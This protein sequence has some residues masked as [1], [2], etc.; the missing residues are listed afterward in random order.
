VLGKHS[1]RHAFAEQLAA[2][3]V[4][5]EG[6]ALERAFDR[7][8][9]LADRKKHLGEADLVAIASS[10]RA[11][12]KPT[13]VL[14]GLQ[15]GCGTMGL[16]TAT[17]RLRGPDEDVRIHAAVGTGPVD[18]AFKA[19]DG[20]VGAR[21]TLVEY[22]VHSVTEGIDALGE[23]SVRVRPFDPRR[24]ASPQTDEPR[25]RVVH[26]HGADTDIVVASAKAYLAALNR[27]LDDT[28]A[29]AGPLPANP[30][31]PMRE[32]PL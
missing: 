7:F 3:G 19:I 30:P 9:A 12:S 5:L 8:K 26:G 14:D 24:V 13:F 28:A 10:E 6:P 18:A 27:V 4:S 15:V 32:L 17:V 1:G 2:L 11:A 21:V 16:P 31:R 25:A 29:V 22:Q 20:I 23:V